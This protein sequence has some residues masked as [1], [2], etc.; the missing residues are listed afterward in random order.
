MNRI[1]LM[2][3]LVG[4]WMSACNQGGAQP[5]DTD[6]ENT[7]T[8]VSDSGLSARIANLLDYPATAGSF[9]RSLEPNGQIRGVASRDWTSGF[10]PGVLWYAYEYTGN[11]AYKKLAQE[12]TAL[13]E[14]Q[15]TNAGTHDMGFKI[16]C[17]FGNGYRITNDPKYREIM[18][19]SAKTLS[20]RFNPVVGCTR[21]WDF[22][23]DV[24]T[25][26]VIIDNMMNLE[27]LFLATEFTGDS[28]YY[29][30]AREH[31]ITTMEN[32]FREDNSSWHVVDYDP[33]TGAVRGKQTHQGYSDESSWARG[34]AWGLYGYTMVY[35]FTGEAQFLDQAR[36]IYTYMMDHPSLPEDLIPYW[37]YNDPS[38]GKP[39]D[40]SAASV[41]ASAL[42]ELST[43][44]SDPKMIE[45]ADAILEVLQ[46][47][48]YLEDGTNNM[49]ILTHSTG[50]MPKDDEVD[51]P[52]IYA[53]YYFME[54]L[55]RQKE[56]K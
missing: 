25:F 43:Y 53:D 33:Q 8:T 50:N 5:E 21:S 9:P 29:R 17:S 27:L 12:W 54:A 31:A 52:L 55:L 7:P 16:N 2:C 35:R 47:E 34:Q 20:T 15:K 4:M 45:Q 46:S 18:V 44:V 49:F 39:R 32:H 14:D 22:N 36:K 56:L 40:V 19:E 48:A 38:T 6:V 11:E 30:M 28:S 10:Y 37:D 51:V 42:Y 24:W 13:V 23:K 41:T 26:P 1:L 3:G